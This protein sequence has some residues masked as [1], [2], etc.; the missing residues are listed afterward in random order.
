M[1][2][3]GAQ[4]PWYTVGWTM[5]IAVERC[6]GRAALVAAMRR[7]WTVLGLYNR[8]TAQC[9]ARRSAATAT[10]DPDTVHALET[11]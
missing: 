8:A 4:G 10:W 3:F 11:P 9:P 2:F 5:A 1:E 6:V 7:P